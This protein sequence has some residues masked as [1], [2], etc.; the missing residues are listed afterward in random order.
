M[1]NV[2]VEVNGGGNEEQGKGAPQRALSPDLAPCSS[3]AVTIATL[4]LLFV[5]DILEALALR[6][7]AGEQ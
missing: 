5:V 6:P 4:D 7:S 3:S 1:H 2:H